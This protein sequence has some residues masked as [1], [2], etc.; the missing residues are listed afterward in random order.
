MSLAHTVPQIR[1]VLNDRSCSIPCDCQCHLAPSMFWRVMI[2]VRDVWESLV[3]IVRFLHS[4]CWNWGRRVFIIK[5]MIRIFFL[6]NHTWQSENLIDRFLWSNVMM[7]G[8]VEL[9]GVPWLVLSLLHRK[10]TSVWG[11]GCS[12]G[13]VEIPWAGCG[14]Y[15]RCRDVR[16]SVPG[17]PFERVGC[18]DPDVE[19][20]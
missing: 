3:G 12:T 17:R 9:G 1:Y 2:T 18:A 6:F 16:L 19:S 13:L 5:V 10:S 11:V 4:K 20:G 15:A 14:G 7:F 8:D